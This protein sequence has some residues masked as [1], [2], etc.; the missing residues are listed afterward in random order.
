MWV[1][2]LALTAC[3]ESHEP[4]PGESVDD[5]D[6]SFPD[7]T[8]L[9]AESLADADVPDGDAMVPRTPTEVEL[10]CAEQPNVPFVLTGRFPSRAPGCPWGEGD[11]LELRD[12]VAAARVT[13]QRDLGIE[14][15]SVLCSLE[16][17]FGGPSAELRYDDNFVL[18]LGDVVLAASDREMTGNLPL[19]RQLR[20]WDW[21]RVVGRPM[22]LSDNLAYCAGEAE[23][24]STCEI[25]ASEERGNAA[26]EFGDEFVA[27]VAAEL[28]SGAP[29]SLRFV[30]IGDNDEERDCSH[31]A[32]DFEIIGTR[33]GP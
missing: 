18:V 22:V 2:V 19:R 27:E 16:M 23:G 24:L 4:A 12:G 10:L 26:I 25:P 29:F 30:T 21:S 7:A 15:G 20:L 28:A 5:G 31:E 17:R 14:P 13:E 11:N 3:Y 8:G 1:G 9:D 6:A 32:I 33:V